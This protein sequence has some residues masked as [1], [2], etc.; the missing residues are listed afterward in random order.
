MRVTA[1]LSDDGANIVFA[2]RDTGIGIA[3]EH[4]E[5]IFEEFSQVDTRLQKKGQGHRPRPAAC[6]A[7]WRGCLGGDLTVESVPGAGLGVLAAPFRPRWAT[8]DRD[9]LAPAG[10]GSKCVLLIDDDET[11]RYVLRQI[12]GNESRYEFIEADGGEEGLKLA[13]EKSPT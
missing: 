10:D 4:H 6:R 7:R 13:R 12:V 8:P 11:F 5:R 9:M 2:V 1:R 3:P